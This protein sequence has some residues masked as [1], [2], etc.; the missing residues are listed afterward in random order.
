MAPRIDN[1]KGL[2]LEDILT[3]QPERRDLL[4]AAG[5]KKGE[6]II[7]QTGKVADTDVVGGRAL[8][9][10]GV[11]QEIERVTE[12]SGGEDQA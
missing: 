3:G 11:L 8:D 12:G 2:E 7:K 4:E 9:L 5:K 10:A 1:F 6:D